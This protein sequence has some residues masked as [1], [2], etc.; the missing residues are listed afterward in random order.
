MASPAAVLSILVE[1]NTGQAS[2]SLTRLQGQLRATQGTAQK[3][4]AAVGKRAAVLGKNMAIAAGVVGV[5]S[6]KMALDFQ[7]SMTLIQTQAGASGKEVDRLSQ[8]IL[9]FAASG[10][11]TFGPN[12]LA[13]AMFRIE[14]A[15]IRGAK[16][17]D[18]LRHSSDLAK[19]GQA[20]L[21]ETTKALV[22]AQKTG[23]RGSSNLKE[24]I[25][26]LNA[27][28]GSG[29]LRLEDLVG[30]MGTGFLSAATQ[31]GLKLS[32][33]GAALAE[34]T[35]QGIP[36]SA[37]ATRLRMT[38]TLMA[39]PT[40]KA[41][42]ALQTIGVSSDDLAKK[43]RS[44]EGL[45]GALQLLKDHL[46]GLSKVQQ[47]Q[48]LAGAFGG[49]RSG[50]TILA[51][52]NNLGD[53]DKT[54]G[55]IQQ[56]SGDVNKSLA[57]ADADPAVR[58]K[59]AWSQ[60]QSVMVRL[61]GAILPKVADAF[62]QVA[63]IIS[64]PKL[65][66]ADKFKRITDLIT[67]A[68]EN[69]AGPVAKAVGGVVVAFLKGFVEA[70]W[71]SDLLGKLFLGAAFI[72]LIGGKGALLGVGKAMAAPIVGGF[73]TATKEGMA[74][75][76]KTATTA[77]PT[78]MLGV[79]KSQVGAIQGKLGTYFS[80]V[81]SRLGGAMMGAMVA[82]I[83]GQAIGGEIGNKI[84]TIGT[85][86]A[87]GFAAAPGPWGAV[88]GAI[89][90]AVVTGMK[91]ED[92]GTQIAAELLPKFQSEVAPK[93]EKAMRHLNVAPLKSARADLVKLK[94]AMEATGASASD[95]AQV[96]DQINRL[97]EGIQ[98]TSDHAAGIKDGFRFLRSGMGASLADI[99]K[100]TQQNVQAI[101]KTLGSGTTK[102]REK[103]AENFR[104]SAKA[105]AKAMGRGEIGTKEGMAKIREL[106]QK[107]NLIDPSRKQAHTFGEEWAKG[108]DRSVEITKGGVDKMIR[109][110]GKMPP[111]AREIAAKTALNHLKEARHEHDITGKEY[112][113]IRSK[114]LSTYT[115]IQ[116]GGKKSSLKL[117]QQV[118][119][120]VGALATVVTLGMDIIGGN[121]NKA[122]K[123]FGVKALK[124]TLKDPGKALAA[125]VGVLRTFTG[126]RGGKIPGAGEG[127]KV[128]A[129]LEPGEFVVNK[130]AARVARPMLEDLNRK[131]PRFQTGGTVGLKPGI[132]RLAGILS[133][134]F[135]MI[136]SSG[137]RPGD[138]GSLHSTGQAADFVGGDWKGASSYVAGLAKSLLEGIYN[139]SAH[140]GT[141]VSIDTF[142]Q[143]PSSFWGAATWAQHASHIHAAVP[144][145]GGKFASAMQKIARVLLKGPE[146][147]LKDMGQAALDKTR[148]AANRFLA[149]QA[150]KIGPELGATKGSL[151]KRQ[152][153]SL[154]NA[155]GR[156]GGA[157]LMAAIALAESGGIPSVTN[158][159]G[160]R[161]LWQ[162]IPSTARAFG[163]N[164]GRLTDPR[165]NALG[166][167]KILAGQGLGAW[168]TYSSGAYRQYLQR[169]GVVG[170]YVGSFDKGGEVAKTGLGL[171][172]E[173]EQVVPK[174]QRGG[175][176]GGGGITDPQS[177]GSRD[178]Q[179]TRGLGLERIQQIRQRLGDQVR[180]VIP[181]LDERIDIAQQ[182]AGST[183]SP[184]G[185]ELTLSEI[186][187]QVKLQQKLLETLRKTF[188]IA[189][190]GMR[191]VER[192]IKRIED[193]IKKLEHKIKAEQKKA[194]QETKKLSAFIKAERKKD[195]P[196]QKQITKAQDQLK[197]IRT[198]HQRP[199]DRWQGELAKRKKASERLPGIRSAFRDAITEMSGLTGRG[200]R[201]FDT[202]L[203]LS[204]LK[205]S[206]APQPL[207]IGELLAFAEA[208]RFGAFKR[209]SDTVGALPTFAQGGVHRGGLALVGERG[210]EIVRMPPATQVYPSGI[211]PAMNFDVRVFVGNQ[212]I[213]DITRVEINEQER[214]STRVYRAGP[215]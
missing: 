30:A 211:S 206:Q 114:I 123:A 149:K 133:K 162:I 22:A 102:G 212:E 203:A 67:K 42:A 195:K 142:K 210:P 65:T 68:V 181:K 54:L 74:K 62:S 153:V 143:V 23:I 197:D 175:F 103:L 82:Q 125:G 157:N 110:L 198:Q 60:V 122:L 171:L 214:K 8:A 130:K 77:L 87:A 190:R 72:R 9:N 56:H 7:N 76:M 21:E 183:T 78:T 94:E 156:G 39:A 24:A 204:E 36:A 12:D 161:G 91:E 116:V 115:D 1:A 88:G 209:P 179:I 174:M 194:E 48:L 92:V 61:G 58:L 166:A 83:G 154:W 63:D 29:Q 18:V 93:L 139:P 25:G 150:P 41:K 120:N 73:S 199:I 80:G 107:A 26:T 213:K 100:V 71:K 159:I 66:P 27:T 117:L 10:R 148:Q 44:P 53:L 15:G 176:V 96:T 47:T 158:S 49:A 46:D 105:I 189:Q 6:A 134:R 127:D 97:D 186:T 50:T 17:M 90:G 163:L 11:T 185:S 4:T 34:L 108:M 55:S 2:A 164:Y 64:D 147:P 131:V 43:M 169:G 200:G 145:A 180:K 119:G 196:D 177:G 38:F 144:G 45:V 165:Y 173:G 112:D 188:H 57:A 59:E 124:F 208:M 132:S 40:D 168:D 141:A 109:D 51:L 118:G 136:I 104:L 193:D 146:G 69:A 207:H 113:K 111:K 35:K 37:A 121:V 135:G 191:I 32:D 33:V 101:N 172:H 201:I 160:A 202:K 3:T 215:R 167:H 79:T 84:A 138:T 95:I 13:K 128:P 106:I 75:G 140:G 99:L 16:A 14:S 129:M 192:M 170:P 182:V 52:L 86:V 152:L 184:G 81:G 20:D 98:Q 137:L 89:V 5:A 19:L 187:E 155:A 28:V 85:F 31:M 205:A 126:Q 151:S 178:H 70:W